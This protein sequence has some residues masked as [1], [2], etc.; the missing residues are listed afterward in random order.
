MKNIQVF[1][2]SELKTGPDIDSQ[3]RARVSLIGRDN[4]GAQITVPLDDDLLSRHVLLLGGIGT[5]KTNAILQ[6]LKQLR[7]EM[8][9]SDVM[10]IFDTKGDFYQEFYC[11][12]D[13]VISKD[14]KATG[15][16]GPDYWNV[17]RELLTGASLEEE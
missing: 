4:A 10:I 15:P 13:I 14:G 3:A 5:G 9:S 12:G 17:F 1:E 2:G 16:D 7:N 8:P 6:L 11:Q